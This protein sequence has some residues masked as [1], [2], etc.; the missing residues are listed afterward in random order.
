MGG[1]GGREEEE[2]SRLMY[3]KLDNCI[4][5]CCRLF[6]RVGAKIQNLKKL[7]VFHEILHL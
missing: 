2:E 7:M 3:S 5:N 4:T 1:G 6:S